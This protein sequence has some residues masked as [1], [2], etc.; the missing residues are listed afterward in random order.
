M[1]QFVCTAAE[2]AAMAL[3]RSLDQCARV[4]GVEMQKDTDGYGLMMRM[5][6]PRKWAEDGT[7]IWWD[8]EERKQRLY[9]YCKQ[10]VR[11][12]RAIKPVLRRLS[13]HERAI[14]LH[15]ELKNDR[16]IHLDRALVLAAQDVA[17]E[18]IDR[19][20][21]ALAELTGG[22]L[23]EVTKTGRMREWLSNV[24]DTPV[25]SISKTAV[26]DM[27]E[28][29]LD[30][31]V[32][33]V[34]ELRSTTGRSSIA[35]L[36]RM[37]EVVTADDRL[38]GLTMYHGASTGREA[39][40]LVQ[41]GNL[42]RPEW[43]TEVIESW[44]DLVMGRDYDG[45]AKHHP[46]VQM[47]VS[48]LRSMLCAKP[49]HDLI[50]GDFASIEARVLNILAGQDDIVE[51][52][53]SGADVYSY[54][55]ARLPGSPEPYIEGKK[56]PWR[57]TGKF[58][59]LGCGY[60]MGAKKAVSAAKEVYG[61]IITKEDAD[62]IVEGYRST[63]DRVVDLWSESEAAA[64]EAVRKP[65]SVVTFGALRNLK[66]TKRGAWLY[67]IL[68]SK[69]PLCY[70][71]PKIEDRDTPWGETRPAVTI[72]GINGYTRKWERRG[73]YGGL[74]VENIV[75]A[76]SRDLLKDADLRVEEAGYP[77]ILDVHDEI[78]A[79]VPKGFGSVEEFEFLL[80]QTPD[81]AKG[82]PIKAEGWRGERYRK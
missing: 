63:H 29:D 28:S 37:L 38:H 1:E 61:L 9:E 74:W 82:W 5:T 31:E 24:T 26:R 40:R 7:P 14:Y 53:A 79:E 80:E 4:T 77:V 78:V 44:I 22:E 55:A 16:G 50:A 13:P 21:A 18:G 30:P 19:A 66:F 62:V 48:M 60:Q 20:N 54:N 2:A 76:V 69:R 42:P 39:H 58:Q 45:M 23:T 51:L 71:A 33:K 72:S 57:Q 65:G 43:K 67:L 64:F 8:V 36:D 25:K 49:G 56:H 17:K 70:A 32:R 68:P 15:T 75:Q 59:E 27:L 52:F 12:E 6:R 34:L 10:D 41:P 81:W 46:P 35:K 11:T 3:P 47:L 73:M